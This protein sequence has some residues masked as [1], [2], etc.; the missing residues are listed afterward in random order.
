MQHSASLRLLCAT[1]LIARC[2]LC[3]AYCIGKT[4]SSSSRLLFQYASSVRSSLFTRSIAP[5]FTRFVAFWTHMSTRSTRKT[6]KRRQKRTKTLKV[7]DYKST[8]L[9]PISFQSRSQNQHTQSASNNV[10]ARRKSA[11]RMRPPWFHKQVYNLNRDLQN[12][13]SSCSKKGTLFGS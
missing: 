9:T 12:S 11:S 8:L 10:E 7:S 4:C 6:S 2:V 13:A 3:F 1:L 5:T